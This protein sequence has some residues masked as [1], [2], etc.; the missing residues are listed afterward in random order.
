MFLL[1][2]NSFLC[3]LSIKFTFIIIFLR[4]QNELISIVKYVLILKTQYVFENTQCLDL[5]NATVCTFTVR[6][7]IWYAKLS[8]NCL[9]RW[10]PCPLTCIYASSI[11]PTISSFGVHRCDMSTSGN[12]A[13]CVTCGDLD[14]SR[15]T[16]TLVWILSLPNVINLKQGVN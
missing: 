5:R 15:V 14:N 1:F 7:V 3:I 4:K 13:M 10:H 12:S 6:H 16:T 9:C 11:R 8:S 2:S